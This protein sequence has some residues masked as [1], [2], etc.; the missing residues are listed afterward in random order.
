M[1]KDRKKLVLL[2]LLGLLA[3]SV[4]YRVMNPYRQETVDRLTHTGKSR[5]PV[6]RQK[7]EPVSQPAA[8]GDGLVLTALLQAPLSHDGQ[9]GRN[10]FSFQPLKKMGIP[11]QDPPKTKTQKKTAVAKSPTNS[12]SRAHSRLKKLKIFG[13][14]TRDGKT[15]LFLERGKEVL[16]IREG[17]R[18]DGKYRVT[19]L[20]ADS[21][22]LKGGGLERPFVLEFEGDTS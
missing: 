11:K 2:G 13:V 4:V 18:I 19:R 5:S 12:A 10:I 7:I 17:D 6:H 20:T 14:F 1:K 8:K 9:A 22:T 16:T 3:L 21:L 15:T